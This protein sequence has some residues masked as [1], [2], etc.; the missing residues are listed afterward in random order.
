[1]MFVGACFSM[2]NENFKTHFDVFVAQHVFPLALES[3]SFKPSS[4]SLLLNERPF[5]CMWK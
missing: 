3:V 1:M 2:L 4:A 5:Y